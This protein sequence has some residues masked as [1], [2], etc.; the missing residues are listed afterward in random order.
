MKVLIWLLVTMVGVIFGFGELAYVKYF[1]GEKIEDAI[2][3]DAG[4]PRVHKIEIAQSDLPVRLNLRMYG[5]RDRMDIVFRSNV[6]LKTG[7]G[8]ACDTIEFVS[9]V[10]ED[11][12]I[13]KLE[14]VAGNFTTGPSTVRNR[15]TSSQLFTCPTT[16]TWALSASVAEEFNFKMHR[17]SAE[18]RRNSRSIN[19]LIAGPGLGVLLVGFIMLVISI[20]QRYPNAA[21]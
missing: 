16:G 2:L 7:G 18:I 6:T 12:D 5:L 20:R 1:A 21:S 13:G 19:W 11:G 8:K 17:I 9:I 14:F 15:Q 3:F 4:K 10:D